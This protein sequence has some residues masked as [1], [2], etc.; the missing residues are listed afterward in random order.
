MFKISFILIFSLLLT[1]LVFGQT[2]EDYTQGDL[3]M[4]GR[5]FD[6]AVEEYTKVLNKYP[7]DPYALYKRGVAYLYTNNFDASISDFTQAINYN[8]DDADSYNNR[9]LALSYKGEIEAALKDFDKAIKLDNGFAQAFINRGS[10]FI[11][12]KEFDKAVKDFDK[13]IKID[14]SNPEIFVQRAR[15]HYAK[16][17]YKKAVKDYSSAIALGLGNS[18]VYYNRANAH[19]KMNNLDEAIKD[20]TS[21][22]N[23]DPDDLDALNN[24]AYTYKMQGKEEEAE[25]DRL[26]VAEIRNSIFTPIDQLE[27]TSFSNSAGDLK[28]D[29]PTGWV[30]YDMPKESDDKT[31]FVITPEEA[32]PQSEGMMVGVTVGIIRNIGK[33][34]NLGSEA[35]LLD[36]WKG[37]MDKNNDDMLVYKLIW[38]K[39]SQFYGH[40]SILNRTT[41]QATENH[42]SFGMFEYIIAWNDNLIYLYFQSPEANF[43]YFEKIYERAYKSIKILANFDSEE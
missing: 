1:S 41:V 5:L 34:L 39:H 2:K 13:A 40:S 29:L 16:E 32:N 8:G 38:Q 17:E 30:L 33:S 7:K 12:L 28:L 11:A 19:F 15:L 20:Y 24:R 21:A 14:P 9:G 22:I 26:R 27:F 36:F 6:K 18:K 10:A 42:L 3:F 43:D 25:K 23:L 35:E 4:Q 31:E 37:S